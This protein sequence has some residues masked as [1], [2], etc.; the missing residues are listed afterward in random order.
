[1]GINGNSMRTVFG[2]AV[3]L[4]VI[5]DWGIPFTTYAYGALHAPPGGVFKRDI[6]N[7]F[8][9]NLTFLDKPNYR[10]PSHAWKKV[11]H[12]AELLK[13]PNKPY[14]CSPWVAEFGLDPVTGCL[15]NSTLFF[16]TALSGIDVLGTYY[17][18]PGMRWL[19]P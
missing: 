2:E 9:S 18:V 12:A 11:K 19:A 8:A 14:F 1:V 6:N 5:Y 13:Q 10:V 15:Y 3:G 17:A 4:S 16:S 7:G